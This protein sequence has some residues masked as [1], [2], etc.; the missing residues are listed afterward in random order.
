MSKVTAKT[1]SSHHTSIPALV[2]I[3][4]LA[5][6]AGFAILQYTRIT[7]VSDT[8][9]LTQPATVN[10][11]NTTVVTTTG[12]TLLKDTTSTSNGD[13]TTYHFD[14]GNVLNI[15]PVSYKAMVLNE[16]AVTSTE[17]TMIGSTA[18][19]ILTLSSAKDGS[20]I[21]VV[22]LEREGQ[23]FDFRGDDTFLNSLPTYVQ[24]N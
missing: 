4:V 7:V 3:T 13:I 17:K 2:A 9:K 8:N 16:T 18:A 22:Q 5:V 23:L 20:N 14:D 24:F 15:M 10:T 19:E 6:L 1:R 12:F 11:T 21:K